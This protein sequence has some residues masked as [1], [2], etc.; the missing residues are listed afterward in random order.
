MTAA[1]KKTG[2]G[3]FNP[4][5][6]SVY[7]FVGKTQGAEQMDY[8]LLALND[9]LEG[10]SEHDEMQKRMDAGKAV[11]L[12]SGVFNLANQH[13]IHN[14]I[15]MDEA[16][17]LH[18]DEVDGFARLRE[19]YV[20]TVKQYED[21]LW[22]YVELDQGGVERKRETRA[23]LEA[24]GVRPIPVYHPI[25]DGWEYF[26]ELC[27]QYDRICLGNIVQAGPILRKKIL[28]T[29]WERHRQY[30]DVWIHVLGMT[31]NEWLVGLPFNSCDSTGFIASLRYGADKP[32][33]GTIALKQIARA[34]DEYSA[35]GG[36]EKRALGDGMVQ[37]ASHHM[38]INMRVIQQETAKLCPLLPKVE[39][40]EGSLR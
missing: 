30:P 9:L 14:G 40:W 12:D 4:D 25:N 5:D 39:S 6:E 35:A 29:I 26:D 34:G 20:A 33:F 31:P 7:F 10:K 27:S 13:A 36:K 2:G 21:Q 38:H 28:S 23:G 24:E 1:K 3:R 22:G 19:A 18:P 37:S 11:F 32:P 16:L 17:S 15:S 8:T